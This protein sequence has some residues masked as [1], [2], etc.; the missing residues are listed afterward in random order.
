MHVPVAFPTFLK[1][2]HH[3]FQFYPPVMAWY[4]EHEQKF[5]RGATELHDIGPLEDSKEGKPSGSTVSTTPWARQEVHLKQQ[6]R[7]SL[8]YIGHTQEHITKCVIL[9]FF[10]LCFS[11]PLQQLKGDCVLTELCSCQTQRHIQF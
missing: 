10:P 9:S 11:S 6:L 7:D 4:V 1:P 2:T 5:L 8:W 3:R